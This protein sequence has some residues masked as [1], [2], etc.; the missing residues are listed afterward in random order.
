[1][2]VV[3]LFV[4]VNMRHFTAKA[5]DVND[6]K[7]GHRC[8]QTGEPRGWQREV[9]DAVCKMKASPSPSSLSATLTRCLLSHGVLPACVSLHLFIVEMVRNDRDSAAVILP[10][11]HNVKTVWAF[12]FFF[13]AQEIG[14]T[15]N[16]FYFVKTYKME[17]LV[18]SKIVV[19]LSF[20]FC[21][22]F[23][24]YRALFYPGTKRE[25]LVERKLQRCKEHC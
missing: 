15:L 17:S 3:S 16:I 11:D 19:V 4:S 9:Q 1:M 21:V 13:P 24:K 10:P 6:D 22:I 25:H 20:F 18:W 12:F 23:H 2:Y 14:I 7:H 5:Q 8:L